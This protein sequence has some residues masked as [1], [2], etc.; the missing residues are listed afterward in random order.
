M[1]MSDSLN[2]MGIPNN[3]HA[4]ASLR[5]LRE[6]TKRIIYFTP[7]YK[8]I[9]FYDSLKA[10]DDYVFLHSQTQHANPVIL[11]DPASLI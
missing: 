4:Y 6:Y 1:C 3:L 8:Q 5:E 9:I 7:Q 11:V 2:Y 10:G